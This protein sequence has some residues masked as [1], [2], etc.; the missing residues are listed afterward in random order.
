MPCEVLNNRYDW[1]GVVL[2]RKSFKPLA[3][4]FGICFVHNYYQGNILVVSSY[5]DRSVKNRLVTYSSPR[6]P[7]YVK[8]V[9]EGF[10][11]LNSAIT[12]THTSELSQ[13][14]TN[15]HTNP[16]THK[17]T[18]SHTCMNTNVRAHTHIHTCTHTQVHCTHTVTYMYTH[19]HT[20]THTRTY[21][22]ARAHTDRQTDKHTLLCLPA[23]HN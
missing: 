6:I 14:Y 23:E 11:F 17:Q 8:P 9:S 19:T 4:P 10:L 1:Y 12:H 2:G 16:R 3:N 21:T 5:Q 18:Q 13:T 7:W 20:R 15:A 22:H